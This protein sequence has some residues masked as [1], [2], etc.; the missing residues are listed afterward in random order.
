MAETIKQ[1]VLN[2]ARKDK[3]ILSLSIPEALKDYVS[4]T[5]RPTHNKSNKKVIPDSLQFSIFGAV[6]PG[7][8]VADSEI[9]Y[10]GQTLRV[11]SHS[12]PVYDDVTVNFTVDNEFNNYW[13]MWRWLE[14]LNDP[15]ISQYDVNSTRP[16]ST[17][18]SKVSPNLLTDYQTDFTLYGL[19]EYN[20]N[21]IQFTY[22]KAFP[23]SLGDITYS[24]R[25]TAEVE[26]SFAFAFTQ[27]LVKLL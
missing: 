3:F 8:N 19:N 15:K 7:V 11:S 21:A 24:Y 17:S 22:T 14:V 6:V 5:D 1:S 2:K 18:P 10:A 26:S 16:K 12:R 23:I 4:K 20:K 13:Y 27:M 25:D 9:P